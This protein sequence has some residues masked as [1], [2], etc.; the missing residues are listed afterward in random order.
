[1]S[2]SSLIRLKHRLN[3]D[4]SVSSIIAAVGLGA[5]TLYLALTHLTTPSSE[6]TGVV[7]YLAIASMAPAAAVAVYVKHQ[8]ELPYWPLAVSAGAATVLAAHFIGSQLL[9]LTGMPGAEAVAATAVAAAYEEAVKLAAIVAL[10]YLS[11]ARGVREA[12]AV[13]ALVGLGFAGVENLLYV[14][15]STEALASAATRSAVAPVHVLVSAAAAAI[16]YRTSMKHH[17]A[18]A[19]SAA[20]A[21]ATVLHAT[22]NVGVLGGLHP[23]LADGA[24][25]VAFAGVFYLAAFAAVEGTLRRRQTEDR[26][27]Q[28][29]SHRSISRDRGRRLPSVEENSGGAPESKAKYD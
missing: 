8:T 13:G 5:A 28:E 18:V 6:L 17:C 27:E 9:S 2:P 10:V 15:N 4:R 29:P 25:Y 11:R 7:A 21:T 19:A 24:G 20:A 14:V 22:Y 3:H 1:M 26:K 12:A 23:Q 16:Y